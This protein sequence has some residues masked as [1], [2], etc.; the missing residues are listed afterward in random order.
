MLTVLRSE[1]QEEHVDG[2]KRV[3]RVDVVDE[4]NRGRRVLRYA[5]YRKPDGALFC[6]PLNDADAD[7][8]GVTLSTVSRR[9]VVGGLGGERDTYLAKPG[10]TWASLADIDENKK[11]IAANQQRAAEIAKLR[12]PYELERMKARLLAEAMAEAQRAVA[13]QGG[14]GGR[15]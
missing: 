12:D 2:A 4:R 1:F 9:T 6:L 11:K 14:G 13:K 3:V 8:G 10:W 5:V 7:S 15:G